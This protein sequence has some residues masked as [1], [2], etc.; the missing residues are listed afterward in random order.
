MAEKP[1]LQLRLTA[2]K[3]IAM[4]E[5]EFD[6]IQTMETKEDDIFVCSYPRSGT[7]LTQEL[8]YLVQ[9]GDFDK[10]YSV[11]LD[12]RFPMLDVKDDRFPY[13]K[14]IKYVEGLSSPRMIKSHLHYF[15]LPE[16]LQNGKGR[17][18]KRRYNIILPLMQWGDQLN[19]GADTFTEFVDAFVDGTGYLCPWP[20]HLLGYWERRNDSHVLFL[21]YEDVVKDLATAV[22]KIATFLRK[23]L[24]DEE[25]K[26]ICDYCQFNNMKNND[27]CN[28]SY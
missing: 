11:Q 13:Y 6:E 27:K 15:M 19:E 18:S 26:K 5:C 20:K 3:G 7:T 28:M 10:A 8:V 22:R 9:T 16:Q 24:T 14:G 21:K 4:F 17:K 12:E 2:Y 23:D 25:V 1:K